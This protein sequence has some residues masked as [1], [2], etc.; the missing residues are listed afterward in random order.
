MRASEVGLPKRV[1][2]NNPTIL[3]GPNRANGWTWIRGIPT[4]R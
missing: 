1:A 3:T 2:V 4:V